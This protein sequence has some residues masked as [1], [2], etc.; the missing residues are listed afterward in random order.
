MRL[1]YLLHALSPS[2]SPVTLPLVALALIL[3]LVALFAWRILRTVEKRAAPTPQLTRTQRLA[4]L[5]A[6][7]QHE[8]PV[9]AA[10][11]SSSPYSMQVRTRLHAALRRRRHARTRAR[12]HLRW[13]ALVAAQRLRRDL[14]AA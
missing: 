11:H 14:P 5:I 9:Q 6:A 2:S 1:M 13:Y 8:A 3:A 10:A 12:L 4:R 7:L